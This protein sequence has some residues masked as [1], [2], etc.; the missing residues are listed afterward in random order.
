MRREPPGNGRHIALQTFVQFHA[1]AIQ[2]GDSLDKITG[3]GP[4]S[5]VVG[6]NDGVPR[7]A[8]ETGQPLHP[9][10]AGGKIFALVGVGAGN[11]DGIITIARHDVAQLFYSIEMSIHPFAK[12]YIS[13]LLY[14]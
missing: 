13:S 12:L 8:A 3:V 4:E 10:P 7:L 1:A 9:F 5:G 2:F 14:M 11:D 6:R